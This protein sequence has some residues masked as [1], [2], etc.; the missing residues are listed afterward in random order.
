MTQSNL[1]MDA[2]KESERRYRLMADNVTDV[3]WIMDTNLRLTY[4]SPSVERLRGFTVD[5]VMTQRLEEVFTPE[6]L[7]VALKLVEQELSV[8]KPER[9]GLVKLGTVGL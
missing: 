6:S 1:E 2:L 4:I 5:E 3:I 9:I 7:G 8:R